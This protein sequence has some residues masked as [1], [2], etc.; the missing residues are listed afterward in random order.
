MTLSMALQPFCW[1]FATFSVSRSFYTV[2]RTPST[3]DQPVARA[4]PAHRTAQTQNKRTKTS[5]PEVG[6]AMLERA[7][8]VH[9]A[10]TV[11]GVL[12]D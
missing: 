5:M 7:K 4:L 2:G 8:T 6:F 3:E 12:Y 11:I 10:A 1:N 9:A